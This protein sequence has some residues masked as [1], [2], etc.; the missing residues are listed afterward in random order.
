MKHKP[1]ESWI[2]DDSPLTKTEQQQLKEHLKDCPQC[3]KLQAAW[4]E[5]QNRIRSSEI[6]SPLP[7][8]SQRWQTNYFK[9]H[10]LEKTRQVRRT[11]LI[12]VML[13]GM[14]SLVYMLQNNLLI[15]WIVSA[16]SMIASLFIN[17]TKALAGIGELLSET[18]VLLYGF[19]FL[20]LGAIAALLASTAFIL[21]NILKKGSQKHAYNAED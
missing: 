12:L 13:M 2:L 10:E 8:F 18:P 3:R 4:H 11:L 7:G 16:I 6:H 15:T 20:S 5:S 17:I 19:G 9:R 1:F 14:A 21:W